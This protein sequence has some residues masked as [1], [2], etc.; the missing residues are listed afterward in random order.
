M[1]AGQ[2]N[3]SRRALLGAAVALP[4]IGGGDVAV[5]ARGPLHQPSPRAT[6]GPPSFALRCSNV[7]R[8][9]SA[10]RPRPGEDLWQGALARYERAAEALAEVERRTAG[11]PWAEQAAVEEEYGDLLDGLYAALRRLLWLPAP[12]L[13]ALAVKIELIVAHEVATL[14]GGGACLAALRRDARRLAS[15]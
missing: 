9:S 1:A 10:P 7:P 3:P 15:A 11:A 8:T 4:L 12:D 13:P 5:L 2:H 14:N 6:A